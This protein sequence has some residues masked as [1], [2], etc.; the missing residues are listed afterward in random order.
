MTPDYASIF[1]ITAKDC[2]VELA[3]LLQYSLMS[4]HLRTQLM[5]SMSFEPTRKFNSGGVD[6]YEFE[7]SVAT[8]I[9]SFSPLPYIEDGL[10]TL[11]S[12]AIYPGLQALECIPVFIAAGLKALGETIGDSLHLV[13]QVIDVVTKDIVGAS[14]WIITHVLS[15]FAKDKIV[16][17]GVVPTQ[18]YFRSPYPEYDYFIPPKAVFDVIWVEIMSTQWAFYESTFSPGWVWVLGGCFPSDSSILMHLDEFHPLIRFSSPAGWRY[19]KNEYPVYSA[20]ALHF[21]LQGYTM[22]E[23]IRCID[24][25][26]WVHVDARIRVH[27]PIIKVVRPIIPPISDDNPPYF[28]PMKEDEDDDNTNKSK[29]RRESESY[30]LGAFPSYRGGFAFDRRQLLI[31][32]SDLLVNGDNFYVN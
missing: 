4:A 17:P 9:D 25:S 7:S 29:S 11:W 6:Y 30:V 1:I 18:D 24:N 13:Y 27:A 14:D 22:P 16:P 12:R 5:V 31:D 23:W 2:G 28:P 3:W 8:H 10:A 19:H 32:H 21:E 26:V 20:H 15:V